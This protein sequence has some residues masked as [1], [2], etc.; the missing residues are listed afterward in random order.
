MG[1]NWGF[2]FLQ[3]EM[4]TFMK[5]ILEMDI[6]KNA[7]L[8][9][10]PYLSMWILSFGF[11]FISDYLINRKILSTSFSRKFYNSIAHWIP[12]IVL[13]GLGYV[14]ENTALSVTLLTITV[15]LNAGTYVGFM[16]N[17]MDLAPNFAGTL[18]AITNFAANIMSILAPLSV[19]IFID[20]FKDPAQ[21][22]VM[23]FIT[24]AIY[25]VGNLCFVVFGKTD[26]QKWNDKTVR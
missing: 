26:V 18:M 3:T 17:H 2:W 7:L 10:L 24:S 5:N 14:T 22:R 15:G 1:Q 25:I 11:S 4:P 16:V 9:A 19:G 20:D 6:K 8:S 12:A 23:F 21:W 13:I